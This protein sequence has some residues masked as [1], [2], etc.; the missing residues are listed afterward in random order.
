MTQQEVLI[1]LRDKRNDKEK[2]DELNTR[3]K[4]L[5]VYCLRSLEKECT[6]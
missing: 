4:M 5:V 1:R 6:T 3:G 2:W